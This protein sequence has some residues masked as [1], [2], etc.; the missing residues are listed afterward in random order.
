MKLCY[1][2]LD[3]SIA[4]RLDSFYNKTN[5]NFIEVNPG[6]VVMPRIYR[7]I[8]DQV[9][10]FDV[11][12][13]DIW[14]ISYPRTGS[15]WA[16]EMIWLLANDLNYEGAKHLQQLRAPLLEL[17]AYFQDDYNSWITSNIGNSVQLAH[18]LPSPRFIKSHLPWQ[19][20]PK[21]LATVKPKIIYI[22]RNPKDTCVSF[23]HYMSLIHKVVGTFE[24]FCNL[25]LNNKAVCGSIWPHM[26]PFW[27]RRNDPNILFLKYEDMKRDLSNTIYRCADF[28]GVSD[29]LNAEEVSRMC[30]HLNFDKMQRN[31]AVNLEPIYNPNGEVDDTH[32]AKFIR[33]GQI[34]DW[35]NY[36]TREM[37]ERFDEWIDQH[38]SD[39]NLEFEYE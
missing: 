7:D 8:G 22:A 24:E 6:N 36:M 9:L 1:E 18:S 11:R 20:L 39:T 19:L 33:K 31:Q 27:N 38:S 12:H 13:D 10:N 17:S 21:S 16:Q 26:L 25:F 35:K 29:K 4:D 32:S 5:N 28:L 37:S 15:T 2:L 3:D 34:G 14:M 23:Y 30:D